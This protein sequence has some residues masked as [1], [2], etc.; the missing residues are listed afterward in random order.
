MGRRNGTG[1]EEKTRESLWP[2]HSSA[3]EGGVCLVRGLWEEAKGDRVGA[4]ETLVLVVVA[5]LRGSGL[6]ARRR[7]TPFLRSVDAKCGEGCGKLLKKT[8]LATFQ[9]NRGEDEPASFPKSMMIHSPFRCTFRLSVLVL[10]SNRARCR[11]ESLLA[12]LSFPAEGGIGVDGCSVNV[13]ETV[14]EVIAVDALSVSS[15][16]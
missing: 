2:L 13:E 9:K 8:S 1:Y 5:R 15:D 3:K 12:S 16:V 4:W 11:W 7:R 10:D 14:A 6:W